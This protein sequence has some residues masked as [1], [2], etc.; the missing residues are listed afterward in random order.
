M[1]INFFRKSLFLKYMQTQRWY[2]S[3][4]WLILPS[5]LLIISLIL[6]DYNLAII[7][8]IFLAG[9]GIIINSTSDL[10]QMRRKKVRTILILI[11][12]IGDIIFGIFFYNSPLNF[13]TTS[14]AFSIT[15][16][17]E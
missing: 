12:L 13:I 9:L 11:L 3:Y 5:L 2:W 10:P 8:L 17:F 16:G 15:S 14:N 1:M 4:L 7:A 6:Q